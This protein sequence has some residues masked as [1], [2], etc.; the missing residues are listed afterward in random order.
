M[1]TTV[2]Q[3]DDDELAALAR[4]DLA[5]ALG[6]AAAP[7][8]WRVT[9]WGGSLPQYAVGHRLRVQRVRD[10]VAELPGLAVAGAAFDGVGI[11]AVVGSAQY[12]AGR[13]SHWLEQRREWA[14]A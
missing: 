8:A 1:R 5:D 6:V 14:H 10:A 12:A 13:V 11:A 4:A 9:R 3:R 7:V 2:L